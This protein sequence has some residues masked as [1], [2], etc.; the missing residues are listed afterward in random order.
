[1]VRS[2]PV[3][4]QPRRHRPSQPQHDPR[5]VP[6]RQTVDQPLRGDDGAVVRG[7]LLPAPLGG[8]EAGRRRRRRRQRA[9]ARRRGGR[10]R[11]RQDLLRPALPRLAA[12]LR[13]LGVRLVR[14]VRA[15]GRGDPVDGAPALA[16]HL[17]DPRRRRAGAGRGLRRR[18]L[19]CFLVGD[20][21]GVPTDRPWGVRF[22]YGLPPT[23]AGAL[24]SPPSTSTCPPDV[25]DDQLLAVHPTQLYETALALAIWVVG[26][27]LLRRPWRRERRRWWSSP[28]SPS[29]ASRSSSFA[30]RTTA[31]STG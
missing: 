15:G 12:A 1:M 11:R 6:H 25:P 4:D 8:A 23:T 7:R 10:H 5:A 18:P 2:A 13:S 26:I 22:P 29:S 31:S 17:A 27:R 24:R 14:R 3:T 19:G 28:C 16:A 20:D 9:G 30:P 21:Y